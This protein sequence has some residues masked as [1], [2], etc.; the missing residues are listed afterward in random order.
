MAYCTALLIVASTIT[1]LNSKPIH[2][3]RGIKF[4]ERKVVKQVNSK[5][6]IRYMISM[7]DFLLQTHELLQ[8]RKKII[9]ICETLPNEPN[10]EY[11]EKFIETNERSLKVEFENI[12]SMAGHTK[13]HIIIGVVNLIR[14]IFRMFS[15]NIDQE[16]VDDL[17]KTSEKNRDMYRDQVVLFN[18]TMFMN[19]NA[20]KNIHIQIR[21]L[22]DEIELMQGIEST[23]SR[24]LHLSNIIQFSHAIL[25]KRYQL[26]SSLA[27]VL[28]HEKSV[29]IFNFIDI[30]IFFHDLKSIEERLGESE[31]FPIT[32]TE[33]TLFDLIRISDVVI[34][35][36]TNRL[37]IE[38]DIPVLG[39]KQ[40]KYFQILSLP[41]R[42]NDS[43]YIHE[44]L[45][46]NI[47]IDFSDKTYSLISNAQLKLCK[48]L[49]K[50]ELICQLQTAIHHLST[51]ETDVL[52][53]NNTRKCKSRKIPKRDY[54]IR[55]E[56]NMFFVVPATKIHI[57]IECSNGSRASYFL[58]DVQEIQIDNGCS[59][60]NEDF[61]YFV[62]NKTVEQFTIELSNDLNFDFES[63]FADILNVR[64]HTI[65]IDETDADFNNITKQ[66]TDLYQRAN[67]TIERIIVPT[68]GYKGF[69]SLMIT[70]LI[71][72]VIIKILCK[73]AYKHLL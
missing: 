52:I 47:F 63:D 3:E 68:N 53:Y 7:D 61:K 33:N 16:I 51:C 43:M 30:D 42:L 2:D 21:N 32:V 13:R 67:Q 31:A 8:C 60:L 73:I 28:N 23:T 69:V 48:H 45:A 1:V 40:Y 44:S 4:L 66:L 55:Y 29:S 11:Y 41:F 10:C 25:N 54:V 37:N 49:N 19:K 27:K 17:Q 56:E 36:T 12:K 59:L 9:A 50:N 39:K 35:L 65:L 6:T 58:S 57:L 18:A 22:T 34:T 72:Y 64:N 70:A 38:L 20:F 71:V 24:R 62:E 5:W 26:L 46:E 14:C 15:S